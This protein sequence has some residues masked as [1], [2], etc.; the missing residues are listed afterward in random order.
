MR[1]HRVAVTTALIISAGFLTAPV[2]AQAAT[3]STDF[4]VN[5]ASSA[6]CSDSTTDS[7]TAPY[8]TIQ[9][10]VD[11]ATSPGDTVIITSG[12]Y[13]P[14]S[15]T[16]SGTST[17]PITVEAA[18]ISVRQPS[19]YIAPSSST[20]AV[21]VQGASHV[22]IRG[23]N[24]DQ[25]Y[26]AAAVQ[27]SDS[28]YVTFNS[29]RVSKS[30]SDM[31]YSAV[32]VGAD[33]SFV[34]ISQ[35]YIDGVSSVGVVGVQGG[36]GD[37]LTTDA[38]TGSEYGP[39]ISLN[40]TTDSDVTGIQVADSCGQGIEVADGSTSTSIENDIVR[41]LSASSVG[42]DCAVAAADAAE[43]SVDDSSTSGT[44]EDYDNVNPNNNATS[45][46]GL[47][48]YS[49]GGTYYDSQSAFSA[50]TG[51]GEHDL[52][53]FAANAINDANSDAP[54]ELTT[55]IYGNAWVNDPQVA[56]TGAGKYAYYDR[57]P[58]ATVDPITFATAANWPTQMPA[59]SAGTFTA[60]VTDEWSA[61]TISSCTY[62]FGDG[63]AD[64]TVTATDGVCTIR[65]SYGA[66]GTYS[67][68]LSATASDGFS[69]ASTTESVRVS[70]SNVLQAAVVI[71]QTGARQAQVEYDGDDTWNLT[72]CTID[73]GDGTTYT[74]TS[75]TCTDTH[76]YTNV[77]T[78][79]ITMTVSDSGG[80]TSTASNP[81]TATGYYYT[82]LTP[83]R[84]LDTRKPI[85]VSA[86]AKIAA[87]ASVQL[88]LAGT[89]GVPADATAV[90]LTVTATNAVAGGYVSVYPDGGTRPS[91]SNLNIGKGQTIANTVIVKLGSDG[92]V[93]L[94]NG[95]TGSIDLIADLQGY[96]AVDGNAYTSIDPV[97]VIDTRAGLNSVKEPV[98]AGGTVKLDL[99]GY[100]GITAASLNLTVTDSTEGGY[101]TAYPDGAQLPDSSNLNFG[102]GETVADEAVVQVG[103][104]GYV[105]FTNTGTG[106][107]E[108]IVD[109]SGYFSTGT[110]D[111]FIPITPTRYLDT[112]N[113]TGSLES[114]DLAGGGLEA[115]GVGEVEIQSPANTGAVAI[116]DYAAAVVANFTVTEPAESGYLEAFPVLDDQPTTTS[117][118]N[119]TPG[120]T[121]AN[122]ATVG[123]SSAGYGGVDVYNGSSG[124]IQLIVDVFGYYG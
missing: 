64:V 75:G 72:G 20:A 61:N 1:T 41:A 95:T 46:D 113:G 65:H 25:Q 47:A 104:D 42:G 101:I 86:V 32:S 67:V 88:K 44:T 19:I 74:S 107:V 28:D 117:T 11:A 60:T 43:V 38:I 124:T 55:D 18:A 57:G 29:S 6:G 92:D 50:A 122:A 80:N 84:V 93:D 111:A 4:Y 2:I 34:T 22:E 58:F 123:Y 114:N 81:F 118:L 10:A 48:Y 40:Q 39:G 105:D 33:S 7:A 82:P 37:V 26:A 62:D 79:T 106:T 76:E 120:S 9:A 96:Y 68:K 91:V 63:T 36:T 12:T 59:A 87:G 16:A 8:C 56:D 98:P 66:N 31:S 69:A 116:S 5:N 45:P 3:S 90:A 89:N 78:Y 17:A 77:G 24:L 83:V 70:G 109:L 102:K 35:D 15:V 108:L 112:R 71:Y 119:F 23:L 14:F 99:S 13:A 121:V 53:A 94:Y 27:I 97:R 115:Y 103:S 73:F 30:G 54:G 85:G 110:G 51:Q 52:D 49:W 21:T 100:A